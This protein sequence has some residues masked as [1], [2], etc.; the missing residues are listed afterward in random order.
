MCVLSLLCLDENEVVV[1]GNFG[2][3]V[4]GG[5]LDRA[6]GLRRNLARRRRLRHRRR[7][8]RFLRRLRFA[9]GAAHGGREAA[10]GGEAGAAPGT[11]EER[12]RVVVGGVRLGRRSR[13]RRLREHLHHRH[14][15][16]RGSLDDVSGAR[17]NLVPG[18]ERF[19]AH[20]LLLDGAASEAR[21]LLLTEL[22]AGERRALRRARRTLR[23]LDDDGVRGGG[24]A[25]ERG[26][27]AR[28]G[29]KAPLLDVALKRRLRH[30]ALRHDVRRLARHQHRPRHRLGD[31]VAQERGVVARR[32]RELRLRRLEQRHA[33]SHLRELRLAVHLHHVRQ[34]VR[35]GALP[36]QKLE[37]PLRLR[38]R[39]VDRDSL[40]PKRAVLLLRN[41]AAVARGANLGDL[42]LSHE[43]LLPPRLGRALSGP[44]LLG[45][46]RVLRLA[47]PEQD[48]RR[49]CGATL[50][51]LGEEGGR[52]GVG[53]GRG[54]G[55]RLMS[56]PRLLRETLGEA[57]GR[58]RLLRGNADD[59]D[60]VDGHGGAFCSDV[61][62]R[63][64][65]RIL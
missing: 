36:A 7:R 54:R 13:L 51:G 41:E 35:R 18:R 48:G 25:A 57:R 15:L 21:A 1:G 14:P 2:G 38:A 20:E 23:A 43:Q 53:R 5:K 46:E 64:H 47:A 6:N 40:L 52:G 33:L 26:G 32:V 37:L 8:R 31:A 19:A 30:R 59:D 65:F 34:V 22:E 62:F 61:R 45:G 17:R 12:A 58:R 28:L 29:E 42:V 63:Y 4:D 10:R 16:L 24:A 49:R 60:L 39:R 56:G 44:L 55:P 50:F 3:G 11:A 9:A 27:A